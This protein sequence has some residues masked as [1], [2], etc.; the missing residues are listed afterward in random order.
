MKL[1]SKKAIILPETMKIILAVMGIVIL[2][3]LGVKLYGIFFV[4]DIEGQKAAANLDK[5]SNLVAD[6]KE[7]SSTIYLYESPKNWYLKNFSGP[8]RY[9]SSCGFSSKGCLCL[10]D[11]IDCD[12]SMK[13][14]DFDIDVSVEDKITENIAVRT[15]Q[16]SGSSTEID[17]ENTIQIT[18]IE[19]IKITKQNNE[20]KISLAI[21]EK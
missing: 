9:L 13:C 6:L 8:N 21:P 7:G 16:Y 19:N 10:C 3:I 14:K 15:G 4:Q 17:Y 12:K 5:I 18:K 2:I 20:I 1:Q 11:S